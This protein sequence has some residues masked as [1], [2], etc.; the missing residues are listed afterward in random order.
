MV[1]NQQIVV[2]SVS[3]HNSIRSVVVVVVAVLA[4]EVASNDSSSLSGK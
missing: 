1:G 3:T 4:V 2:R